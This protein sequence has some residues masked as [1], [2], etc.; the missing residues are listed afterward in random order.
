MTKSVRFC[1]G[2]GYIVGA[3]EWLP[4]DPLEYNFN[5]P[6]PKIG[7]SHLVCGVCGNLVRSWANIATTAWSKVDPSAL[8]SHQGDGLPIRFR[9]DDITRT[10]ACECLWT[11]TPT[12]QALD[13][14][15]PPGTSLF[16]SEWRCAGHPI[17]ALPNDLSTD[18]GTAD[19]A[20]LASGIEA[21]LGTR[22]VHRT[23]RGEPF[24][25]PCL[26]VWRLEAHLPA[27]VTH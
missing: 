18:F 16:R 17:G 6:T 4:D 25:S 27:L 20:T 12:Y 9:A 22:S 5:I 10:Y 8:F 1:F 23:S 24:V 3:R 19:G 14:E 13:L 2:G 7:C 21:L 11:Q 15:I 26:D